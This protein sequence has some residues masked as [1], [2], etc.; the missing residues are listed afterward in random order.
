MQLKRTAAQRPHTVKR[1]ATGK[2]LTFL[3]CSQGHA[4]ATPT[5]GAKAEGHVWMMGIGPLE[6]SAESKNAQVK[7]GVR[8]SKF[9]WA[10]CH[11]MC[12]AVL[13]G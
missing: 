6:L 7:Y 13:I 12:T 2:S 11:V 3:K 9:I 1:L 5:G 8:S 4:K 10:P